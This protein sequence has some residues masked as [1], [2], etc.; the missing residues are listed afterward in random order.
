MSS[1]S[2]LS[3]SNSVLRHCNTQYPGP[4]S[5]A[6]TGRMARP[7]SRQG[8]RRVSLARSPSDASLGGDERSG[9]RNVGDGMI[10]ALRPTRIKLQ[11]F[12][13]SRFGQPR[14]TGTPLA[15]G[16][17]VGL[18]RSL[19]EARIASAT[20][21][22]HIRPT[23]LQHIRGDVTEVLLSPSHRDD[24]GSDPMA[25]YALGAIHPVPGASARRAFDDLQSPRHSSQGSGQARSSQF[26]GSRLDQ[27]TSTTKQVQNPNANPAAFRLNS[28]AL[29]ARRP[30]GGTS[31]QEL[32][33]FD[34]FVDVELLDGNMTFGAT[35]MA[36][37]DSASEDSGDR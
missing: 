37:S 35:G 24:A 8:A 23:P 29:F 6:G 27:F 32:T 2:S 1:Q 16:T 21:R 31:S 9:L 20:P 33:L 36:R 15:L 30:S 17:S 18:K 5:S 19:A 11:P 25:G 10:G 7:S 28:L 4:D 13:S 12:A 26:A 22:R 3:F 14:R 34:A